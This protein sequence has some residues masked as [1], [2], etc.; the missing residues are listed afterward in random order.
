MLLRSGAASA[1]A[2][3]RPSSNGGVRVQCGHA[4]GQGAEAV[5]APLTPCEREA[6]LGAPCQQEAVFGALSDQQLGTCVGE[7][8]C[9]SVGGRQRYSQ[10]CDRPIHFEVRSFVYRERGFLPACLESR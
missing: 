8:H 3:S 5:L 9:S 6:V 2:A 1:L 4:A 7:E 10:H